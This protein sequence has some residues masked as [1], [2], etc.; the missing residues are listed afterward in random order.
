MRRHLLHRLELMCVTIAT[1]VAT[2]TFKGLDDRMSE[3]VGLPVDRIG[4]YADIGAGALAFHS[5]NHKRKGKHD[6]PDGTESH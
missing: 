1:A 2:G 4:V 5:W 3:I 6:G